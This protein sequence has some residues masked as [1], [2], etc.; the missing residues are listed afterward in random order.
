MPKIMIADDAKFVRLRVNRLLTQLGYEVV[1][2]ENGNEAVK[3]YRSVKPD[4]VLMDITMPDKDGLTALA[5]IRALDPQ[6]RVIMLSAL[7]QQGLMLE[8]MK[9]GA[10]DFVVKPYDTER[11]TRVLQKVLA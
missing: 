11:L 7:S 8:A 9:A 1:E 4:A 2:V 5:E 6:A 10:V 3:T